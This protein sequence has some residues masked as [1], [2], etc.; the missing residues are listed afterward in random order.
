MRKYVSVVK[1]ISI[2]ALCCTVILWIG[3]WGSSLVPSD[4]SGEITDKVDQ[5]VDS[6]LNVQDKIDGQLTTQHINI[7]VED[8]KGKYYS[9]ESAQVIATVV[10]SHSLDVGISYSV[11]ASD[12]AATVDE[13]GKVTFFKS[14]SYTVKAELI[15]DPSIWNTVT[16]YC[17]GD[18]PLANGIPDISLK[19]ASFS[20]LTVGERVYLRLND[21]KTYLG[22]VQVSIDDT[23]IINYTMGVF[24][25]KKIGSTTVH[26]IVS[27]RD[28]TESVDQV[29]TVTGGEMSEIPSIVFKN[30]SDIKITEGQSIDLYDLLDNVDKSNSL[31][32]CSVKSSNSKVLTVT[33]EKII[34]AYSHGTV[35]LTYTSV[36]SPDITNSIDITVEKRIPDYILLIGND[37]IMPGDNCQYKAVSYPYSYPDDVT[38]SVVTGDA[39]ISEKGVLVANS[40]GTVVIRCQST[41]NPD[42]IVEKT[43]KV[44]LFTS[45]YSFVRK[46]MGHMG[47]SALLGFGLFITAI[48]LCPKK[49]QSIFI[50]P[51]AFGYSG[52]SE[53]LQ[54]LAPGRC[55]LFTDVLVDFFGALMG[56]AVGIV[57]YA[58]I[59]I[60]WRLINKNSYNK[61]AT[62][63][64][65]INFKNVFR[66]ADYILSVND[67]TEPSLAISP[68]MV[69]TDV[70]EDI[71]ANEESTESESEESEGSEE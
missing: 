31:Y 42:I 23:S 27:N 16:L 66:S 33:S 46:F 57:L 56:I 44:K 40:Y 69:T 37:S 61:L 28:R 19:S 1:I 2:V 67:S 29:I 59:L 55:C 64:K 22:C 24:Y 48:L 7:K 32:Y 21:G 13:N 9:G 30:A 54:K 8:V 10:P 6:T 18:D 11:N 12:D 43:V 39:T 53:L 60:I 70:V 51:L 38:W 52:I 4:K 25:P 14:G 35:T 50:V 36:Y 3:L 63:I 68:D 5:K 41:L 58:L 49:W 26:F 47:L 15:S 34:H 71:P 65:L 62:A 20:D 17:E 45:S